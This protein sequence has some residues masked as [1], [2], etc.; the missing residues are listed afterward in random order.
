MEENSQIKA[1]IKKMQMEILLR[2]SDLKKNMHLK[3]EA[4]TAL[5]DLNH[6]KSLLEVEIHSKEAHLKKLEIEII[7]IQNELIKMKHKMNALGRQ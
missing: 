3:V 1:E 7:E 2:D 5:R 4:E 6:K